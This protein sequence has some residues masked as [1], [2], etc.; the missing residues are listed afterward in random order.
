MPNYYFYLSLLQIIIYCKCRNSI[1]LDFYKYLLWQ[2]MA[3]HLTKRPQETP[4]IEELDE[5]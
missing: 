1:P 2:T 3:Y 4:I 5:D